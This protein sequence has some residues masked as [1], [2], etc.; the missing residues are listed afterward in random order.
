MERLNY[1]IDD[2]DLYNVSGG[3][4]HNSQ[5]SK[6]IFEYGYLARCYDELIDQGFC[7]NCWQNLH[8]NKYVQIHN[9][10]MK[11]ERIGD[12]LVCRRCGMRVINI[13]QK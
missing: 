8:D 1:W 2:N 10:T 9:I 3:M 4:G 6:M 13:L 7:I 11:A 12:T 5:N